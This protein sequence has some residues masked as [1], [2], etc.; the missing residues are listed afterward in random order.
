MVCSSRLLVENAGLDAS[1]WYDAKGF[2]WREEATDYAKDMV[3]SDSDIGSR[4]IHPKAVS[5]RLSLMDPKFKKIQVKLELNF[6]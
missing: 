4:G 5:E 1:V 6:F 3:R 2:K